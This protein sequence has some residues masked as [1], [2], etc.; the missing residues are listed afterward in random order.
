MLLLSA[1]AL[2]CYECKI[3]FWNL[4][5]TTKTTCDTGE[6]CFSGVGKAA[7]FM[8]IKT[9]GC[10]NMAQCNKTEDVNFPASENSTKLYSMTKTC[11]DTD[12][13]N[14][15]PGLPTTPGLTLALASVTAVFLA[16]V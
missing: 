15:A 3:G 13:C 1:Q 9:K 5:Y 11:C 8:D 7:G 14:A 16:L 6:H 4:C 10:L 12:L 2:Q